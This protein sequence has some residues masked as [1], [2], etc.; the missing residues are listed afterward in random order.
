LN[1]ILPI[2]ILWISRYPTKFT[3]SLGI[4]KVKQAM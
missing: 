1:F 3:I 2:M 4:M